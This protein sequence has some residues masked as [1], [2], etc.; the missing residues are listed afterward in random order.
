MSRRLLIISTVLVVAGIAV[1]L[2]ADPVARLSLGV[3][4][5]ARTFAN[6]TRTFTFGN[7]SRTFTF[8]GTLPFGTGGFTT[9]PGA[10]G[11]NSYANVETL[12]AVALVAV[13]VVLEVMTI[14]LWQ[15]GKPVQAA[16]VAQ[17]DVP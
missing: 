9:G 11:S 7:G 6:T 3:G 16:P 10:R 12:V 13:G 8:N 14:F 1:L 17:K 5:G 4:P 15:G 2:Y